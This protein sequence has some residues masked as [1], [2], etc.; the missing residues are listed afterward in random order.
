M[1]EINDTTV[2]TNCHGN[3]FYNLKKFGLRHK[4]IM[5]WYRVVGLL[6]GYFITL[7]CCHDADPTGLHDAKLLKLDI[8]LEMDNVNVRLK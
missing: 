8:F 4:I 1:S 2:I 3:T 5:M 7:H 6:S